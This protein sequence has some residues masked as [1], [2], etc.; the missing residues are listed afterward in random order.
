MASTFA[1]GVVL[2]ADS[3]TSSGNYVAN[4]AAAKIT[5]LADNAYF[6]RSGTAS[7]TQAIAGYVQYY[8]A[9]HQIELNH[10]PPVSVTAN[11][12]R[13]MQYHNKGLLS[14]GLIVAGYDKHKGAQVYAVPM[15]GTLLKVCALIQHMLLQPSESTTD[16]HN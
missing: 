16:E 15:G 12:V 9:Q 11:L 5:Q 2:A 3:R 14:A 6:C 4:R 1:G 7:D 13:Q 8:L 10:E